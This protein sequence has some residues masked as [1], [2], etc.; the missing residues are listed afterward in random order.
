MRTLYS[1]W[2][3][4]PNTCA[5]CLCASTCSYLLF[6]SR[7]ALAKLK[8]KFLS[9]KTEKRI[10][11]S[12]KF[13]FAWLILSYH[14][15][16]RYTYI[17]IYHYYRPESGVYE[18]VQIIVN[19]CQMFLFQLKKPCKS[20]TNEAM[21]II[22]INKHAVNEKNKWYF[23]QEICTSSVPIATECIGIDRRYFTR[24]SVCWF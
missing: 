17:G 13:W 11:S 2:Y 18:Q 3:L 8:P 21:T 19:V 4:H 12:G 1:H 15:F 22:R 6:F 20:Y 5:V 24:D 7:P 9:T 14:E 16:M 23:V 10:I